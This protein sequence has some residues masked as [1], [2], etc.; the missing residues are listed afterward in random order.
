MN[1]LWPIVRFKFSSALTQWHPSDSSALELLRPW[2][3]VF[4]YTDWEQLCSKSIEP[5]LCKVLDTLKINPADQQMDPFHWVMAWAT[6]I[7][8]D[9]L[10]RRHALPIP[11]RYIAS[12]STRELMFHSYFCAGQNSQSPFLP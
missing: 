1:E 4:K 7:S 10:V 6:E 3:K 12:W 9:R 8:P 11:G 2:R 5:K